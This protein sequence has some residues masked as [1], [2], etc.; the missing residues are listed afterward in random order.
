MKVSLLVLPIVLAQRFS[1]NHLQKRA[2]INANSI[3]GSVDSLAGSVDNAFVGSSDNALGS[4]AGDA[5]SVG[6]VA[7]GSRPG[8]LTSVTGQHF[9]HHQFFS[10][11]D[12]L[13][14]TKNYAQAR[15]FLG[16][17]QNTD[18][19]YKGLL[20]LAVR[21]GDDSF[22]L[23]AIRSK[24]RSVLGDLQ[25]MKYA[26]ETS[27]PVRA[28]FLS[29]TI[30]NN[31]G[32]T[33]MMGNTGKNSYYDLYHGFQRYTQ[34]SDRAEQLV[35]KFLSEA[36]TEA[37]Q[38]VWRDILRDIQ[39]YGRRKTP[40]P[41][42]FDRLRSVL[43]SNDKAAAKLYLTNI[44]KFPSEDYFEAIIYTIGRGDNDLISFALSKGTIRRT[45]FADM[46]LMHAAR[47]LHPGP[48]GEELSLL[49]GKGIPAA[50]A[51]EALQYAFKGFQDAR[52]INDRA[53]YEGIIQDISVLFS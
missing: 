42:Y 35:H 25:L 49:I 21:K 24:P 10:Q 26:R 48:K 41:Q 28:N 19:V 23:E 15:S 8:L 37:D 33:V 51:E 20:Q 39:A 31:M 27:D 43:Y 34:P 47:S 3:A 1:E 6:A 30:A 36:R 4:V 11:L 5:S 18:E 2:W 7:G 13:L 14:S 52:N 53:I 16:N 32:D 17:F 44:D 38:K 29:S 9:N 45:P 40:P 12:N 46:E 22:L 50:K